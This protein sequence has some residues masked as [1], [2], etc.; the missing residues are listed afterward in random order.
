MIQVGFGQRVITPEIGAEMPGSISKRFSQNVH[1]DLLVNAMVLDDGNAQV[2]LAGKTLL[3]GRVGDAFLCD[4]CGDEV[5]GGDIK[6]GTVDFDP[7]GCGSVTEAF[8]YF[9]GGALLNRN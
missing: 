1:D 8:R 5:G 3:K 2:V 9:F 4:D 6:R 7:F